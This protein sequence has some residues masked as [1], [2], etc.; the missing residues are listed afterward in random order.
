MSSVNRN[1]PPRT[2]MGALAAQIGPLAQLER[3]VLSCLLWEDEFYE[4]GEI[5]GA[6]IASLVKQVPA[7]LV[8]DVAVRAKREMRLRHVP[9]LLTRE[10]MRSPEGRKLAGGLFAQVIL[11]ADDLTEFLAIYWKDKKDEPLAKQVKKH[12]GEAFRRFDEYHLAK[13]NGG[14]KVVKLRDVLRITRPKPANADQAELWRRL[15]KGELATP[16]TW[17]VNLSAG[18][19][20]RATFARLMGEEKLGTL[21]FLRNLRNMHQ[22]G[23]EKSTVAAYAGRARVDR[24]LPFQFIAA[25]RAVPDWQDVIEPMML[26]CLEGQRQLSGKTVLVIDTSGSM[27]ARLSRKSELSRKDVAAALAILVREVC[28]QAVVYCTAGNDGTCQHATMQIPPRRGF[29]LS[30]YITGDKVAQIGGG[31]I[32]LVQCMEA[33]RKQQKDADRVIVLTDEQDCDTKLKPES[34]DAFG[35]RNY[36]IN[37]ASARNGVGYGKW[38]HIDGWSDRVLD[39]IVRAEEQ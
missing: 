5:I 35:R 14:Q 2:H 39:Y 28:E 17:E 12:L 8:A 13:Y 37:V 15:V 4:S 38:V 9:L 20:K 19:D 11:R 31:G 21:A 33:I 18:E 26:R 7:E 34:A 25:F 6:R 27:T 23:V 16:D 24:I 10:L 1:T 30:S 36:L 3:S 32:F 29:A 22:A